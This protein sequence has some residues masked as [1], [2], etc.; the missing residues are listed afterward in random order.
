MHPRT[1][2]PEDG[3]IVR[4]RV[5]PDDDDGLTAP[6]PRGSRRPHTDGK[7]ARVRRLVEQTDMTYGAI[8]KKTGVGRATIC[9]WTQDFGWQRHGWAPRATDRMP[10]A[11]ASHRLKARTLAR[12]LAAL[13]ERHIRELEAS[14][15]VDQDKLA[16]ALEL[17]K[18]AKVAARPRKRKAVAQGN[19]GTISPPV[20]PAR[21]TPSRPRDGDPGAGVQALSTP[22][23]AAGVDPRRTA[24]AELLAAGIDPW[25]VPDELMEDFIA[26]RSPPPPR[27]S[28]GSRRGQ[29]SKR[30]REHARMLRR[31]GE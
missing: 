13:A 21:G 9:R 23:P 8:S 12:R 15:S 4:V 30:N 26:S 2:F 3:P 27:G 29:Y 31:I 7:V 10:T 17:L 5:M 11:R 18:M 14:A 16:E 28:R 25:R 20:T 24:M 1:L 22:A 6:R 19:S